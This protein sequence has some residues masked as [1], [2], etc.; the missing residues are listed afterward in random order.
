MQKRMPLKR[1]Y[2]SETF[3]SLS[4]VAEVV[5]AVVASA[6][7]VAVDVVEAAVDVVVAL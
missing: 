3:C 1:D 4:A 7:V 5:A 2:A 6:V